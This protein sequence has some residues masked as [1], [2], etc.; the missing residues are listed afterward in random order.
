MVISTATGRPPAER[1]SRELTAAGCDLH[2]I[3]ARTGSYSR[4]A[5]RVRA[6]AIVCHLCRKGFT[7][8]DPP[9]AD[10]VVPRGLGG[11]DEL[12]NLRPAHRSC[13]GRRGAKLGN[14]GGL[15]PGAG[16]DRGHGR[17]WPPG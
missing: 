17:A 15:Y 13:N 2:A 5:A 1:T 6:S 4:N 10:H 11:S 8:D 16:R 3:P 12:A 14:A 7:A 9:V